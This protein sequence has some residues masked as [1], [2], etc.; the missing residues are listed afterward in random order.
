MKSAYRHVR[1]KWLGSIRTYFSARKS[2]KSHHYAA[3]FIQR[4]LQ[5]KVAHRLGAC[6]TVEAR[7][8][9]EGDRSSRD[10]RKQSILDPLLQRCATSKLLSDWLTRRSILELALEGHH[11]VLTALVPHSHC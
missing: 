9:P 6:V 10:V 11:G 8:V 1:K 4:L 3:P 7:H 2:L 5:V